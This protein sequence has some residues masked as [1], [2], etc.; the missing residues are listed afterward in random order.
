[1]KIAIFH[2]LPSGGGKRALFEITR[3]LSQ[4]GHTLDIYTLSTANHGFC[5]LR[6]FVAHHFVYDFQP[7]PL[8]KSPFGRMN[9]WQ[10]WRDLT[11][12]NRLTHRIA[13]TIDKEGYDVVFAH[14]CMWTQ[15]P[16]LLMYLKTPSIYYFQESLRNIF[17]PKIPRPYDTPKRLRQIMDKVD[18]FI[19][20]FRDTLVRIDHASTIKA[21]QVLANSNFSAGVVKQIYQRDAKVIYL[22]VDVNLYK[23]S[24][25]YRKGNFVL[26]VGEI[27]PR[28]GFDFLIRVLAEIPSEL[29]PHLK[30]IGNAEDSLELTYLMDLARNSHVYLDIETKISLEKLIQFYN[31]ALLLIYAPIREPFGLVALEAMACGTP[32]VGVSEGGIPESVLN[33]RTGYTRERDPRKFAAAVQ[34]LLSNPSMARE[35]GVNARHHIESNWTWE[36]TEEK[37]ETCLREFTV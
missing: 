6:P 3:R 8:Y 28:K 36:K 22:G 9:Q 15:S 34:T 25:E 19:R 33:N 16:S 31:E 30:V 27:R 37:I 23:P 2:D 11:R 24:P 5:D 26:S 35:Y 14:P 18:P 10:R 13:L 32:V 7:L 4:S 20:L 12:L 29:R 21:N 1:M 17:E